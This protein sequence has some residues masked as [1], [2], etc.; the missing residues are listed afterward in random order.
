MFAYNVFLKTL[1]VLNK[2]RNNGMYKLP[3]YKIEKAKQ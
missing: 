1:Y 3:K 2:Y